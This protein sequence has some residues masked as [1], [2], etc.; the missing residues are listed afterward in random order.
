[1]KAYI[2]IILFAG[3]FGILSEISFKKGYKKLGIFNLI[4]SLFSLCFLAGVRDL[5]VG[6]DIYYYFYQ[7]F[8]D[9]THTEI[10]I[11]AEF[12]NTGVDIGFIVLVY[13]GKIFN[14][15]SIS[16]FI[17]ELAVLAPI[18]IFAYRNRKKYSITF[19]I[20]IYCLTMYVRS[21]NLMRQSI[22]ISLLILS[23]D[24]FKDR[25]IKKSLICFILATLMHKTAIIGLIIYVII[26]IRNTKGEIKLKNII[27]IYIVCII[28]IIVLEPF[29]VLIG[30]KYVRYL[31]KLI[32]NNSF[33]ILRLAKKMIWIFI[34]GISYYISRRQKNEEIKNE[35][36]V[37]FNIFI[38]DFL[39]ALIA[40]K[41]PGL[42]KSYILFYNICIY[43]N[44]Y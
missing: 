35:L 17:V 37:A 24:Y 9:F 38:I 41:A 5:T 27:M 16:M 10:G 26:Y 3:L 32:D 22:A 2:L 21:F 20:L 29:L 8:Y 19:I 40:I 30:S 36:F 33:S 14:N 31:N 7:I 1:M 18:Y 43:I 13:I 12:A 6:T 34:A 28:L 4:I 15:V 44:M 23:M 25:N 42:R 39:I 11:L